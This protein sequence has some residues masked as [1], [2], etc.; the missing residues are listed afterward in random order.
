MKIKIKIID[1]LNKIANGEKPPKKIYY[2]NEIFEYDEKEKDYVHI[3]FTEYLF[4]VYLITDILNDEVE[5]LE[6]TITMKDDKF[7]GWEAETKCDDEKNL[8]ESNKIE[9][10]DVKLFEETPYFASNNEIIA[11]KINEIIEAI[12]ER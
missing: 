7:T 2:K 11:I 12:N 8:L 4:D 5:I 6:T 10:L 1:I 3:D 9:K